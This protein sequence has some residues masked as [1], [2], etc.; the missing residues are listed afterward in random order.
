MGPNRY[1][2]AQDIAVARLHQIAS[3][4]VFCFIFDDNSS[5]FLGFGALGK[6]DPLRM[7]PAPQVGFISV[8]LGFSVPS[9]T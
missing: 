2:G 8:K 1:G 7:L 4:K 3:R 6:L 9:R 5:V